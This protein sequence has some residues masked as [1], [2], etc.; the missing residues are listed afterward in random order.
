MLFHHFQA[1][2]VARNTSRSEF[3]WEDHKWGLTNQAN[4]PR[5][6]GA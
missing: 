3:S 5:A 4:R 2:V 1:A 6:D